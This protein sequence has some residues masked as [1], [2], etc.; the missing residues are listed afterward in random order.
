MPSAKLLCAVCKEMFT[1]P[2]DLMVHA[3]SAHTFNIYELGGEINSNSKEDSGL[4]NASSVFCK[5]DEGNSSDGD[6][7]C[8]NETLLKDV[9]IHITKLFSYLK[10]Q[11]SKSW[12][13][14]AIRTPM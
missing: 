5:N 4:S 12:P 11:S 7:F 8:V 14:P 13:F 1:S 3:Q 2:W 10:N 6:N 9:S